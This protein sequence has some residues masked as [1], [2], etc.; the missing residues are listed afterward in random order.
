MAYVYRFKHYLTNEIIYIGKTNRNIKSRINEHFSK[1]GHLSRKCYKSVGKIEYIEVKSDADARLVEL[2][3]I[4]KY[5]PKYNKDGKT[6]DYQSLKFSLPIR[7]MMGNKWILY[8]IK[9]SSFVG[10]RILNIFSIFKQP[11]SFLEHSLNLLG[12]Y[13][14]L[15][16]IVEVIKSRIS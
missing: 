5:K 6:K 14:I 11:K 2:Y 4:N 3:L 9:R 8:D 16:V 15:Y 1:K 12:Y 7:L 13:F 10:F